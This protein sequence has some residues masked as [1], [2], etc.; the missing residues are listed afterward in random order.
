MTG[1]HMVA[2]GEVGE[3]TRD[4]PLGIGSRSPLDAALANGAAGWPVLPVAG[5]SAGE[6]ACG[7]HDATTDP[8]LIGNCW[9][10]SP[11]AN[12]GIATG[13][14]SGLVVVDLDL[15][16][17]GPESLRALEAT[18]R[19]L[20]PTMAFHTGGMRLFCAQPAG[21]AIPNTEGG[22]PG[23]VEALP[24]IDLRGDGAYVVAPPLAVPQPKEMVPDGLQAG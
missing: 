15:P 19:N 7:M 3:P 17:G 2:A 22:L 4:L 6:C 10:R 20:S 12:V 16:K 8:V 23:F 1:R 13:A 14:A 18:V 5:A 11:A 21:V 24:G 9:R